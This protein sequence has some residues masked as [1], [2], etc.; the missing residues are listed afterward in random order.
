MTSRMMLQSTSSCKE[1]KS[2]RTS[3]SFLDC[4]LTYIIDRDTEDDG[5]QKRKKIIFCINFRIKEGM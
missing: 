4:T 3:F 1:P 2:I 5:M